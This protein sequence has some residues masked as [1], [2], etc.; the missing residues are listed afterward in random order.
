MALSLELAGTLDVLCALLGARHIAD[1]GSGFSSYVFQRYAEGAA[2]EVVSVDAD[3]K[4]LARTRDFLECEGLLPHE[5]VEWETF[6]NRRYPAFDFV[7]DDLGNLGRRID[8]IPHVLGLVRPTGF[9]VFDDFH[10][11]NVRSAVVDACRAGGHHVFSLRQATLDSF[12]RYACLVR[13]RA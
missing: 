8:T 9:V 13:L 10:K 2:A 6:T 5:L 1:L 4:W 3:T 7:L 12:G 11:P